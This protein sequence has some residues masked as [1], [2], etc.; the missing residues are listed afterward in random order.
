MVRVCMER[1][2]RG[3]RELEGVGDTGE[4]EAGMSDERG[5]RRGVQVE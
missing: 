4:S 1:G 2:G 3:E 5:E